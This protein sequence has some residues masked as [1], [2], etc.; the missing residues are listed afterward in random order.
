MSRAFVVEA[1]GG[2]RGNPGHAA[3]GALVRD[4]D[5]LQVLAREGR[6]IGTASNNVAE[7]SGLIAGLRLA[8]ALDPEA[9]IEVRM[10]SK[11]RLRADVRPV[12]DQA[13]RHAPARRRGA[14][15]HRPGAGA[16][17]VGAAR[18]EQGRRPAGQRGPRRRREGPTVAGAGRGAAAAGDRAGGRG[19]RN[20]RARAGGARPRRPAASGFAARTRRRR[21]VPARPGHPDRAADAAPR[22]D[23]AH[24]PAAV[25]RL[26]RRRPGTERAWAAGRRWPRVRPYATGAAST[27]CSGS[28]MRRTRETAEVVAGAL[29]MGVRVD[30]AWVEMSF[31]RWEGLTAA[32]P[33]G[34][35]PRRVRRLVRRRVDR[36]AGR[37]EPRRPRHPHPHRAG[38][39]A[40]ALRRTPGAGRDARRPAALDG[41]RRARRPRR[42]PAVASGVRADRA[43]RDVVVG[44]RRR[45]RGHV[46]RDRS[47]A[48][49]RHRPTLSTMSLSPVQ[50]PPATASRIACSPVRTT[51]RS[52][53]RSRPR[54]PTATCC[55]VR[56]R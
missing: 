53:R 29:G 48:R 37:R 21:R 23:R 44:R 50:P 28:P 17:H 6:A 9:D 16:L 14:A 39:R 12:A 22:G 56:P 47:P 26:R 52:A 24:Q 30:D 41:A 8:V 7:Y 25:R 31:G 32:E 15:R 19:H 55:T 43:H 46:E 36:A 11:A 42:R 40:R 3:Y 45:Q 54:W 2:S 33:A 20:R 1:D 51:A 34:E 4:A 10:D 38:P 35:G 49:G 27:W 5:T 13:R 18:A